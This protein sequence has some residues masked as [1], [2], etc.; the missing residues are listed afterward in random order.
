MATIAEKLEYSESLAALA[1]AGEEQ[2]PDQTH[3]YFTLTDRKELIRHGLQLDE[4]RGDL[5]DLKILFNDAIQRSE[6]AALDYRNSSEGKVSKMEERLRGLEDANLVLNTRMNT[7]LWLAGVV[8]GAVGVVMNL[9]LKIW[10][11]G[12]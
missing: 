12:R 6:R 9:V 8:G 7:F 3:D 10:F 11:P 4:M 1:G 2:M 5:L